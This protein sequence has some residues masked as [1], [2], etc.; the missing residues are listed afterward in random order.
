MSRAPAD[1]AIRREALRPDASFAVAA[2]AGSGKT[3][4]LTQRALTLLA[5]SEHPEEVLCI[6]FTRKAAGEMQQRIVESLSEAAR[7]PRPN[8]EEHR[9]I[10]WDLAQQVLE[11]DRR[12]GWQLLRN[13]NRLRIQTIDGLCRSIVSQLPLE[14]GLGAP[15]DNLEQPELAYR[16]AVRELFAQLES[17]TLL[18]EPLSRLLTHL[19]NNLSAAEQLLLSLLGNREQWLPHLLGSRVEGARRWLEQALQAVITEQLQTLGEHLAPLEDRLCSLLRRAA[20]HLRQSD[21][22]HALVAW[23]DRTTLPEPAPEAV[24]LW[25]SLASLLLTDKDTLRSRITVKEGFPAQDKALKADFGELREQLELNRT[26]EILALSRKLPS[27]TY[28]ERQWQ[29]LTDLTQILPLLVAQL[30]LV[31]ANLGATDYTEVT[32][33][34]L[35]AL[36]EEDSPSEIALKLD[37]RI[38]HILVDE[39]QDTSNV[40]LRLLEKLTAGWQPDD[41]RTLF[42]VGDGMQSCYGFRNAN[43]GIFLEARRHGIGQVR[44]R[45]LDLSVN[46]RSQQ[47]LVDWVNSTFVRAFPAADD[48]GRGAVRYSPSQAFNPELPGPAVELFGCLSKNPDDDENTDWQSAEGPQVAELARRTLAEHPDGN[49]AILVRTRSHLQAILPALSAAGLS[50]QATE[51]DP[52]RSR[53]AVQD[54]LS[55]TRA[56]LDPGDRIA[57]L[58]I[59]RAPWCGLDLHDLHALARSDAE[60]R[61]PPIWQRLQ[62][63]QALNELSAAARQILARVV[64]VLT[65]ALAQNRRKPLRQWLEGTWLALGGPAALLDSTDLENVDSFLALLEQHQSGGQVDDWDSFHKAMDKLYARPNPNGDGRLQIM[66]IHKSKGLEFDTVIVPGLSRLPR[67]GDKRLLLWRE[68]LDARGEKQLLLGTLSATGEDTDPIYNYMQDEEKLQDDYEATRLLY[69]ACTRASRRLYLLGS[70]QPAGKSHSND[71]KAPDRRSL[72]S[73]IWSS[74]KGQLDI[75]PARS[76]ATASAAPQG[77]QHLL[78]LPPNWQAPPAPHGDLLQHFRGREFGDADNLPGADALLNRLERYTG[79]AIHRALEQIGRSGAQHW[80]TQRVAAQASLWRAHLRQ[81]G[82]A[83]GDLDGAQAQLLRAVRLT[84]DDPK[85]RWLLDA[86]HPHS[87]CE[88]ALWHWQGGELLQLVVDRTFVAEGKRWVV[89]YKSATPAPGET[90]E[91]FVA[92][93]IEQYRPQLARYAAAFAAVGEE[94]VATA[95][96]FPLLE[97]DSRLV[98][99]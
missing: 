82:V 45:P 44:L 8:N 17:D 30:K 25:E 56:L 53:M 11:Q 93:S 81:L 96:Y 61:W 46:F 14:S 88:L 10:T 39:F 48:I 84:L 36:G 50:W 62:Q 20:G 9:Q 22:D 19:D 77:L 18:Q 70:L 5:R 26:N 15:P 47:G 24:P 64:P 7:S 21:P 13:P 57:W 2:P 68:R 76:D 55:L 78:R 38:R 28:D 86:G 63:W 35:E 6:T 79:T 23:L 42:I 34:A 99:V 73:R 43:V 27:A 95:L 4:L 33:A 59:L 74:A 91:A 69:V 98:M 51:I 94:P 52:L 31:F 89:D 32:L 87:A 12:Q 97:T 41:G 16:L 80:D 65:A 72:F 92:R 40:Q 58:S 85:G 1:A 49:L 90:P 71:V 67:S 3:A 60:G 75:L 83:P 54:L 29:L 66:T 37:Y